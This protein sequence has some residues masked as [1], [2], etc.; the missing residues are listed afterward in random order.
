MSVHLLARG[1]VIRVSTC[2]LEVTWLECCILR[3]YRVNFNKYLLNIMM[4]KLNDSVLFWA[5]MVCHSKKKKQLSCTFD[6]NYQF[7]HLSVFLYIFLIYFLNFLSFHNVGLCPHRGYE[8]ERHL[9]TFEQISSAPIL[10][11]DCPI[12]M[13]TLI[14]RHLYMQ[15]HA[16]IYIHKCTSI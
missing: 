12:G 8:A 15:L 11:M 9:K 2:L 3:K 14:Y 6:T 10:C 7:D 1:H 4:V 16:S 5:I 13:V